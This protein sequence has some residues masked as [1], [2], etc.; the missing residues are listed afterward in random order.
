M[1]G[2]FAQVFE[3]RLSALSRADLLCHRGGLVRLL[4]QELQAATPDPSR[5][6]LEGPDIAVHP[7]WAFALSLLF[8]E[9]ATNAARHGSLSTVSGHVEICWCVEGGELLLLWTE[10]GGPPVRAPSSPGFGQLLIAYAAVKLKGSANLLYFQSGVRC[11]VRISLLAHWPRRRG[12]ILLGSREA[13][14]LPVRAM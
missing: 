3:Q 4:E 8:H 12:A 11:E 14:T 10:S 6:N 1:L 13:R 5:Y 9:L 2:D 7:D